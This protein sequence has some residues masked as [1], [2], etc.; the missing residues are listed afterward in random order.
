MYELELS[1]VPSP[2]WRAAFLARRP[3]SS[4]PL[5]SRPTRAAWASTAI[6]SCFAPTSTAFRCGCAGWTGGSTYANSVV[7]E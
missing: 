7:E 3:P 6:G 1:E 5:G 2:A 4:R